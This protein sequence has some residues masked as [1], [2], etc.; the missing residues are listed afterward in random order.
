MM[1]KAQLKSQGLVFGRSLQ[2][3]L[4]TVIMYTEDHPAA[5]KALQQSFTSLNN[6]VKQ[7]PQFTFGFLN[8]RVLI[9][10]IL[11]ED[12]VLG[13]L[14]VEF[15][16]R[17][18]ATITFSTGISLRDFKRAV[19][20][21][22]TKP[23]LIEEQ[24]G[25]KNFLDHNVIG[26]VRV[27]PAKTLG[28][29]DRMLAM[30]AE[31]YLI[32]EGLLGPQVGTG[33]QGLEDFL[34]TVGVERPAGFTG[35]PTETLELANQA[36]QKAL[37]DA[38][39][40]PREV[41]TN[42]ARILEELSP[43]DLLASL[44]AAQKLESAGHSA[45][46]VA[47]ELLEDASARWAARRLAAAPDGWEDPALEEDVVRV[48]LRG[49][50]TTRMADRLM[51]KLA[52]YLEEAN[53]PPEAY[54]RLRAGL[55]WSGLSQEEKYA[56]LVQLDRYNTQEF[57]RLVNYLKELLGEGKVDRA[58]QLATHYF[59]FL[60]RAPE[61]IRR[62]LESAPDLLNAMGGLQTLPFLRKMAERFSRNL[63]DSSR[64]D[65]E[66]HTR[67]VNCLTVTSQIAST[68]E[69]FDLVQWVG[70]I[71][72]R[73][74][75]GREAEHADCCANALGRLLTPAAQERLIELYIEKRNDSAW[76]RT[77]LT[78]LRWL[79]GA[80]GEKVFKRLEEETSASNRMR[81]MRLLSQLGP[82]AI[83]LA[84]ARL[85]DERWYVV[86]NACMVVGELGE[87]D[88]PLLLTRALRHPDS[89]VQQAALTA[90][91][92]SHAPGS[93][94]VLAEALPHL[95]P[96][97]LELAL[98]ELSFL[99]DQSCLEGLE[100]YL[101]QNKGQKTTAL[102]KAVHVLAAVATD[103][104]TEALDRVLCDA[105]HALPIRRRALDAMS[106]SHLAAAQ[107]LLTE[108]ARR[109]PGDPLAVECQNILETSR[110]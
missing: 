38:S 60:D 61:E 86:R 91:I 20:L 6:L 41:V 1:D 57:R 71:L 83:E 54:D 5:E 93:A 55:M 39:A 101:L 74:V 107:E 104:A 56:K 37:T 32:A 66:C 35:S 97:I 44:P 94:K 59:A 98:D 27:L 63:L 82:E 92:K 2:T 3:T 67:I 109:S 106:R 105:G 12:V 46:D 73:S 43:K 25:I 28:G 18:I 65:R 62:G 15:G 16:K 103:R 48:L 10:N 80:A 23:K 78:L 110:G 76:A 52:M 84:R 88:L 72:G 90:I 85:S 96:H 13:Q 81:L 33:T 79:A 50:E 36:A 87:P 70:A 21:L 95:H 11:T 24:G 51:H 4:K 7:M 45:N 47:A 31:S 9:N 34:Q 58:I 14:E 26:G 77:V 69:D 100:Q 30:D 40:N 19:S 29:E 49:L 17:G 102:D 8:Q 75:A 108:F 99:K 68:Y 53:L 22:A 42:L 89:R 64:L